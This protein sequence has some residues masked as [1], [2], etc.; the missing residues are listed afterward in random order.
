MGK[1]RSKLWSFWIIHLKVANFQ[2]TESVEDILITVLTQW[3]S[4]RAVVF[5]R[6]ISLELQ[7]LSGRDIVVETI[8]YKSG[9]VSFL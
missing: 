8:W 5:D 4:R 2:N 9:M 3:A 1:S 6:Y 7:L